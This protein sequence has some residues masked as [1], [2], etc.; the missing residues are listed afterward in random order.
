LRDRRIGAGFDFALE[1]AQV[2]ERVLRLRMVLRIGGDLDEEVIAELGA[3]ER[4][5]LVRVA[6]LAGGREPGGQ[7]AAQGDQM[8]DAVVPIACSDFADA[9]A[10]GGDAGDVR[11]RRLAGWCECRAR[12]QRA[13][14]RRAAGAIRDRKE[15]RRSCA[16]CSVV[17][18][19]FSRPSGVFGGKNS[20]LKVLGHDGHCIGDRRKGSGCGIAAGATAPGGGI[21]T[22]L[23]SRP[24][25]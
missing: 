14:A 2:L 18:R 20:K 21:S 25:D 16:S 23:P 10:R 1:I 3:D 17:A 4:D 5:Q 15:L 24:T 12:F 13:V 22:G 7:I 9:L 8:A 6:E 11:C 19:S